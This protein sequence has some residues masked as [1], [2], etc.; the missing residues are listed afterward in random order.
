MKKPG[1]RDEGIATVD[2]ALKAHLQAAK[3]RAL[4][5]IARKL[6]EIKITDWRKGLPLSLRGEKEFN[7]IKP[8]K[9]STKAN[10]FGI[11]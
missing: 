10:F 6:G 2:R 4:K 7:N 8:Q 3:L 1:S 11:R 5:V 9:R